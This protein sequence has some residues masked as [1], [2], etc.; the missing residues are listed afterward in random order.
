[1][2]VFITWL[3]FFTG[4]VLSPA[5]AQTQPKLPPALPPADSVARP[6]APTLT[7]REALQ[8]ALKNSLDIQ[9]SQTNV[10]VQ[11][12]Y[13]SAG[14]AGGLPTV[15]IAASNNVVVNNTQQ[16]FNTGLGVTRVGARSSQYNVGLTGSYLLYNGG[17][18]VA[19]RARLG[20]LE[21]ISQLQLNSTVQNVLA[22]VSLKYYAVVQQQR[23]IRTLEASAE[24]SRQKLALIKAR[25]SVGL[26]NNADLFQA[27]LDLNAQ[28][29]TKQQQALAAQQATADLLRSLTLDLNTRVAVEDTI[30]VNRA[31]RW[32]DIDASLTKNPD[33]LAAERQVRVNEL[34]ERVAR[35]NRYPSLSINSGSN[36]ARNQNAVG[37]TLF[38]QSYGP[39][40]GLSLGVPIYTGGTNKRLVKIA[41]LNTQTAQLQR[42]ALERNYRTNALKAWEAYQQTLALVNT[43]QESYTTAKKLLNLVQLRLSAGLSTLVDVKLAQQSFEDAGYRLVNYRYNAKSA[44]I[45]LQQLAAL[46]TP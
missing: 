20:E 32:E 1:M 25:Q 17:L 39:Y 7:L 35:A 36:F 24:V 40:A 31:L 10:A 15:G 38:N 8:T 42:T 27:Q 4:G 37:T 6:Q 28:L 44:E 34:L 23:Y 33:L 21:Q 30:P 14:F 45:T 18:V 26:A 12:L 16:E 22:D 2:K 3:L 29:E 13:N 19:T 43:A 41:Q 9:V 5:G 46:L 11:D